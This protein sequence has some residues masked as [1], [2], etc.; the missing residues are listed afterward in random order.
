MY[1]GPESP[2]CPVKTF[3]LYLS[4]LNPAL[5]CLWQGPR[6]TEHFSHSD[7]VWYCNVPLAKNTL[8][9]FMSSIS[10]ELNF[11]KSILITVLGQRPCRSWMRAILRLAT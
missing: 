3:K 9:S 1:E 11:H 6:A 10:N 2:Y 7:E 8:G 4:K 5:S